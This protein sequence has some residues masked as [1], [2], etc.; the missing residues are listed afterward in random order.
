MYYKLTL[1]NQQLNL[2]LGEVK[3]QISILSK[4]LNEYNQLLK[5]KKK[6]VHQ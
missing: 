6:L 5:I 4:Q 2:K 1:E 3:T